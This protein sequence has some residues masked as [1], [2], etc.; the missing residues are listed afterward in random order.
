MFLCKDWRETCSTCWALLRMSGTDDEIFAFELFRLSKFVF[1]VNCSFRLFILLQLSIV[2]DS[3]LDI[4]SRSFGRRRKDLSALGF[5]FNHLFCDSNLWV[6]HETSPSLLK[7]SFDSETEPSQSQWVVS[8]VLGAVQQGEFDLGGLFHSPR[9]HLNWNLL[10]SVKRLDVLRGLPLTGTFFFWFR[11]IP[12]GFSG[13]GLRKPYNG[14]SP[15]ACT[16]L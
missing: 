8:A 13:A 6:N 16:F 12:L 5:D 4:N 7:M 15:P 11:V 9:S 3:L 14:G 2:G 10:N 1:E